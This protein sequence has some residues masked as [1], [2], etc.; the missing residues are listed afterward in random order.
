MRNVSLIQLKKMVEKAT[1]GTRIYI[2]AMGLTIRAIDQLTDYIQDGT[3]K[4]DIE[5]VKQVYNDT[6]SIMSGRVI[7]PQM[8]Y[9]KEDK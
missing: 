7:F 6:E 1:P 8:D 9:I 5:I 4:P 2:N 3:L